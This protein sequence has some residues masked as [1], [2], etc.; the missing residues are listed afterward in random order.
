MC[1]PAELRAPRGGARPSRPR[2]AAAARDHPGGRQSCLVHPLDLAGEPRRPV[3]KQLLIGYATPQRDAPHG[4]RRGARGGLAV[5]LRRKDRDMPRSRGRRRRASRTRRAG[6]GLP[7][8][9]QRDHRDGAPRRTRRCRGTR[10][11]AGPVLVAGICAAGAV[12]FAG[13]EGNAA[14]QRDD[15]RG[16]A[17]RSARSR[18]GAVVLEP[19]SGRTGSRS[20]PAPRSAAPRTAA[21]CARS[22][23]SSWA[24]PRRASS[25]RCRSQGSGEGGSTDGSSAT[26]RRRRSW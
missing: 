11:R 18:A 10:P 21:R 13:V 3:P 19:A 15:W 7:D 5:G 23:S 9:P 12:A 16:V 25:P 26:G 2:G 20:T 1:W 14:Y 4:R 22:T 6:R 8:H 17:G 24:P